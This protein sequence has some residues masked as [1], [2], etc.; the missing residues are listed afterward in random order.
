MIRLFTIRG[1]WMDFLNTRNIIVK[2]NTVNLVDIEKTLAHG[3]GGRRWLL[4]YRREDRSDL[5]LF[6]RTVRLDN[7]VVGERSGLLDRSGS[8]GRCRSRAAA[9]VWSAVPRRCICV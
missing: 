2:H 3:T 7:E 9:G 6:E 1:L 8:S 4:V 5:Q